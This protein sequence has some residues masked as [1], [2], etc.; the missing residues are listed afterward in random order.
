MEIPDSIVDK[1]VNLAINFNIEGNRGDY[2][3]ALAARALAAL[4]GATQVQNEHVAKVARL[5]LQHRRPEALQSNQIP[6][7]NEDD[8]II[9][10]I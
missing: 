3:I 7:S 9:S 10:E 5:A 1:C 4:V 6:W 2:T 8:F